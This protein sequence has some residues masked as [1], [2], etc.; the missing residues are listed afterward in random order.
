MADSDYTWLS[1]IFDAEKRE[2][3]NILP[4]L[5]GY[6][7][8]LLGHFARTNI[9]ASSPTP[10]K[11]CMLEQ[12]T[13]NRFDAELVYGYYDE[14]PFLTNSLD[15]VVAPHCIEWVEQPRRLIKEIYRVIMPEGY[16]LILGFNPVSLFAIKNKFTNGK[17]QNLDQFNMVS[18]IHVRAMLQAAGFEIINFKTFAFRPPVRRRQLYNS[19]K[20]LEPLGHLL[21]PY[22]GNVYFYL[23][24][25]TVLT[26][27]PIR[28]KSQRRRVSVKGRVPEPTT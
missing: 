28:A 15:I 24:K 5:T 17:M 9:L 26:M 18:S 20:F 12:L 23:V 16:A 10:Y 1:A 11:L 6:Y 27:T 2:L 19:L 8:L 22:S 14:L 25:K 3:D 13:E 4:D 21:W 7:I